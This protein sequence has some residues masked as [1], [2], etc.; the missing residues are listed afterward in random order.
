VPRVFENKERFVKEYLLTLPALN[1]VFEDVFITITSVPLEAH[2]AAKSIFHDK[3]LY[4]AEIYMSRL[5]CRRE[6]KL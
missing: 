1:I 2:K 3:L 6:G 4:M 5:F